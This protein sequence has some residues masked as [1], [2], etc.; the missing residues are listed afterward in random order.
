MSLRT[1][2]RGMPFLL[3]RLK[4]SSLMARYQLILR[5]Y[6]I[7]FISYSLTGWLG[8]INLILPVQ[9]VMA[10]AL[11]AAG[12]LL[13]LLDLLTNRSC[14]KVPH[15]RWLLAFIVVL[16]ISI[17]LNA[18]YGWSSNLK[19]LY[20]QILQVGLFLPLYV[21]LDDTQRTQGVRILFW[22]SS[23]DHLVNL[24]SLLCLRSIQRGLHRCHG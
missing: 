22:W 23:S 3:Q 13:L 19:T 21:I 5:W 15:S 14:F 7:I 1:T 2:N 4:D 18:N 16:A 11:A 10:A 17:I 9:Q 12:G 24:I 20:W 8:P 6:M